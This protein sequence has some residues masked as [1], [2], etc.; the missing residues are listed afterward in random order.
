MLRFSQRFVLSGVACALLVAVG[1]L[2]W[3]L[4]TGSSGAQSGTIHNCPPAGKWSIAVWDGQDGTAAAD[5]L[6]TCGP[7][8]VDE[9]GRAHV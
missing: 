8:A 2:A 1:L 6:A 3:P 7:D 5:A 9:I 4:A